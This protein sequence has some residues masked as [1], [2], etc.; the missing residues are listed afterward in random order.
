MDSPPDDIETLKAELALARARMADDAAIIARQNL[1]I[2]KLKRQIYGPRSEH[3]A[4][5]LDQMELAPA[6]L[7]GADVELDMRDAGAVGE[8]AVGLGAVADQ[9]CRLGDDRFEHGGDGLLRAVGEDLIRRR[10]VAVACNQDGNLLGR[11]PTNIVVVSAATVWD[12]TIKHALARGLPTDMLVSGA[13]A[14]WYF[15]AARY[16]MLPVT[17]EHAAAVATAV[18]ALPPLHR[19]PF[20]RMIVAQALHEPLRLITHDSNVRAYS[21]TIVL[22]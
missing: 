20:D 18:A 14:L 21:D 2:A 3:T 1:E 5:L 10:L 22:V 16:E 11:D 9:D 12:I 8:G 13:D 19:A 17:A 15:R 4:R 6:V 7:A